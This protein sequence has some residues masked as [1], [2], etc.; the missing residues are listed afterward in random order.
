MGG[1]DRVDQ[2]LQ[3][4]NFLRNSCKRYGKLVT[5]L[6]SQAVLNSHKVY[7]KIILDT[8]M[9]FFEFLK[10]VIRCLVMHD[11]PPSDN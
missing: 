11:V 3:S 9:T 1:V 2:Q 10:D 7:Q 4:Y 6:F 5:R 8:K